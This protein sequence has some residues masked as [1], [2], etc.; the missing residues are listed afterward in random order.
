MHLEIFLNSKNSDA[1]SHKHVPFKVVCV[2][3]EKKF[4]F[5]PKC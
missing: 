5:V 1:V 2:I 3:R 4:P